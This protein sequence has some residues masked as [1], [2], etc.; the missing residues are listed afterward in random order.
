MEPR[1][2]RR[3]SATSSVTLTGDSPP[4][5]KASTTSSVTLTGDSP[6]TAKASPGELGDIEKKAEAPSKKRPAWSGWVDLG[7]IDGETDDEGPMAPPKKKR[8][9]TGSDDKP[10]TAVHHVGL[11]NLSCACFFNVIIQLLKNAL[12]DQD[13]PQLFGNLENAAQ[14]GVSEEELAKFD[15][16]HRHGGTSKRGKRSKKHDELGQLQDKLLADIKEAVD[17]GFV[18]EISVSKQLGALL[19]LMGNHIKRG[20]GENFVSPFILQQVFAHGASAHPSRS[21]MSGSTQEDAYELYG[22]LVDAL[23]AE[24][25]GTKGL[26]ELFQVKSRPKLS[27]KGTGC[28]HR[29]DLQ[30]ETANCWN[31][32]I[33]KGLAAGKSCDFDECLEASMVEQLADFKCQD[34]KEENSSSKKTEFTALP[35]NLVI[36]INRNGHNGQKLMNPMRL[37]FGAIEIG[38]ERYRMNAVVRHKGRTTD[39][40]HYTIFIREKEDWLEIDDKEI[41]RDLPFEA[42]R[43]SNNK[44]QSAILLLKK[45]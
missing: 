8:A 32:S 4:T 3:T 17:A 9:I 2:E 20:S 18:D 35:E 6:P 22:Q 40:G 13:L 27:C 26:D 41:M 11:I 14:F 37:N 16:Q 30:E 29:H 43:D 36:G 23:T 31:I 21:A 19:Q 15:S 12:E 42:L 39:G 5:A 1:R 45:V 33:P 28:S 25:R 38:G 24:S 44:G 10:T 34:C 7:D